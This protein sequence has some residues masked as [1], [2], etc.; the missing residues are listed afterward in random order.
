ML[1]GGLQKISLIDYPEKLAAILFLKGCNLRCSYCHNP[2]LLSE[3]CDIYD[4][5]YIL[6][7][8]KKRKHKL[9]AVVLSGGEPTLQ[10]GLLK[11]AG[12]LKSMGYLL[13]LDTN[14]TNPSVIE[15]L[16]EKDLIDYIAMDIKAPIIKYPAITNTCTDTDDILRSIDIIMNSTLPYEFR[17]T[18]PKYLLDVEDF[19]HIGKLINGAQKYFIQ[20]FRDET[21]LKSGFSV[22]DN[23][24]SKEEL[25]QIVK[26]MSNYTKLCEVR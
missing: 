5:Q 24:F 8:L 12:L 18:A 15:K 1:I 21:L 23:L 20:E 7:F 17:T 6:D 11:F 10:G 19:K 22:D 4:I 3:D 13:K 14:G 16:L 2:A 9:D 26:I 25:G